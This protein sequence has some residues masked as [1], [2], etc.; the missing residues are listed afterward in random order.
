MKELAE[1]YYISREEKAVLC[2]DF[3]T[4]IDTYSRIIMKDCL[5]KNYRKD[6]DKIF[7]TYT[8]MNKISGFI[9]TGLY[10]VEDY[11][12]LKSNQIIS[13]EIYTTNEIIIGN[14]I[15]IET[16]NKVSI[17]KKYSN[18]TT[19]EIYDIPSGSE[20]PYIIDTKK[21]HKIKTTILISENNNIMINNIGESIELFIMKD[22]KYSYKKFLYSDI[23]NVERIPSMEKTT[24]GD[25]CL[26]PFNVYE[27]ENYNRLELK[28]YNNSVYL[29]LE[30]E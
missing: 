15:K 18:Y 25:I 3:I 6:C 30:E 14:N 21:M 29:Y 5:K 8:Y 19:V 28:S 9:E 2:M 11:D 10:E 27:L 7:T 23:I 20:Q 16:D 12:C 1:R 22:N 4:G 13:T 26:L 17:I 24:D